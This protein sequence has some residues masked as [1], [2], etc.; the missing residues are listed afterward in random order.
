[1]ISTL[2]N[3]VRLTDSMVA[4]AYLSL[5]GERNSLMCFMFHSL[6]RNEREIARK[7]VDPLQRTTV[8]QLRQL[9]EYYLQHEYR[10]IAPTDL[11]KGLDPGG[12]YAI[13]TF[14]DGYYNNHLAVPILEEYRVPAVFF[15]ATNY[16][17]ENRCFWWDVLY[18]ERATQGATDAQIHDEGIAMKSMTTEQIE[19]SLAERFGA[20]AFVPRGDIDRPFSPDELREFARC[21]YVRLGN[22]TANHAILTNYD[23]RQLRQQLKGAQDAIGEMTGFNPIAIAYPNGAHNDEV[24]AAC[25]EIGLKIGFTIRPHKIRLPVDQESPNLLRLGRFCPHGEAPMATQCRTYRSDLLV[26][27]KLR[28]AYLRVSRGQ[29]NQ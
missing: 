18:R 19:A 29:V 23:S 24:L 28:D 10:F 11:L 20:D 2:Q 3:F 5:F 1:M 21:P 4:S 13:I 7:V 26:Y 15:I 27:G 8:P 25:R 9:I 22:H 17:K 16:V 6:F 12:K 14:D